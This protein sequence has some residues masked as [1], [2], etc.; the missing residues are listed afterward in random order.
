MLFAE[1][2]FFKPKPD[3]VPE[4]NSVDWLWFRPDIY[5][6]P[7]GGD[8]AHWRHFTCY[9]CDVTFYAECDMDTR[10]VNCFNCGKFMK[11]PK[12]RSL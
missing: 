2:S 10:H 4:E 6:L 1:E 8:V 9:K 3:E 11:L 5:R 12:I 7:I